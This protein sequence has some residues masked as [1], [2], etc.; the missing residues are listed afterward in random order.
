MQLKRQLDG[1]VLIVKFFFVYINSSINFESHNLKNNYKTGVNSWLQK[2][3]ENARRKGGYGS[4][5]GRGYC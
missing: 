4:P 2:R 1:L 3:F 5:A